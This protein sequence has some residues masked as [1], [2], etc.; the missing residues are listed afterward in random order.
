MVKC[1]AWPSQNGCL[2]T[3]YSFSCLSAHK[4]PPS[5]RP[6]QTC[7][8]LTPMFCNLMQHAKTRRE[9]IGVEL[10]NFQQQLAKMQMQL[11]KAQENY[12]HISQIRRQA[13]EQLQSLQSTHDEEEQL[14]SQERLKVCFL[15][16]CPVLLRDP[17]LKCTPQTMLRLTTSS[18]CK[19]QDFKGIKACTL[20][21]P[22][23][24]VSYCTMLVCPTHA[25]FLT[26]SQPVSCGSVMRVHSPWSHSRNNASCSL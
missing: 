16:P 17:N 5:A 19:A 2:M 22:C 10:Y 25:A 12:A 20:L 7:T 21:L 13:E 9:A 4:G 3:G 26:R 18:W 1:N 24:A 23:R 15:P 6:G 14:T 11:E 8:T